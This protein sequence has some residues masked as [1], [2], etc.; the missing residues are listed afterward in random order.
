MQ[1]DIVFIRY[2]GTSANRFHVLQRGDGL[3]WTGDGWSRILDCA[4]IFRSHQDAQQVCAALARQ[5]YGGKPMRT[6]KMEV[7]V[8]LVADD[9]EDISQEQLSDFIA[10]AVRVDVE[11]SLHND[12]PVEGSFVQLRLVLPTL[13]ETETTRK[14]F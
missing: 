6:F 9:V 4:A 12:G 7:A 14:R 2:C 5:R 3:F 11:N 1:N 13:R 10:R 8:A